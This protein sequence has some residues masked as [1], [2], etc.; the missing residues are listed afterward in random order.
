MFKNYKF[1]ISNDKKNKNNTYS[2]FFYRI[3][4][5]QNEIL[6]KAYKKKQKNIV[7]KN[8]TPPLLKNKHTYTFFSNIQIQTLTK[9]KKNTN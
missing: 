7:K 6:K 8:N 4:F 3:L 9:V 5:P 1:I 2:L